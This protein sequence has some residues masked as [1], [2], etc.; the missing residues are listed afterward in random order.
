MDPLEQLF[1][2]LVEWF[3]ESDEEEKTE[4]GDYTFNAKLKRTIQAANKSLYFWASVGTG[5]YGGLIATKHVNVDFG[6]HYDPLCVV[7]SEGK[8][9][10]GE[11]YAQGV[12]ASFWY[13]S[14]GD[15]PAQ[16]RSY[17]Y[18]PNK[19]NDYSAPEMLLTAGVSGYLPIGGSLI[20]GFDL[21]SFVDAWRDIWG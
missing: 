19:W 13:Y 9:D 17:L 20:I 4:D 2:A 18:E 10:I 21:N 8:V 14:V 3:L 7:Y 5:Y 1:P 15:S 11:Y 16:F 12:E 6:I